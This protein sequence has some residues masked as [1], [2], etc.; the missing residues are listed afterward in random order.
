MNAPTNLGEL[1]DRTAD[2]HA[3]ALVELDETL[4]AVEY[5]FGELDALAE[6]VAASLAARYERGERVALLAANS[7]HYVATVLG[8]MRAG[9]IAVPVNFR[10]PR[11]LIADV[12]A[13]S[14]A[15]LVF[16]DAKR[17]ADVP[18]GFAA[19]AFDA[20]AMELP[21]RLPPNVTLFSSF[22][23]NERGT[24][25]TAIVPHAD[26]PALMLYT[27]GS[28]GRP[29]GVVLSHRSHLWVVRT[30]LQSQPLQGERVLIAA[31]LFHMNALALAFLAL[32]ARATIVMLPQFD[33][34]NY[35]RAVTGWRCT[36][37]TAVPPMIAMMMQEH[38]LLAQSDFSSVRYVRMGS[39]PVSAA[40][41]EQIRALLPNA[42]V[43]NAYGTTEGGPVVFGPHPQDLPTPPLSVGAAHPLVSL[44]LVDEY[45]AE[46]DEGEL[47]LRSPA[48]MNGYHNRPD[49]RAPLTPDG[50]Y[51]TG[52][53]FQRDT[54]GFYTFV[55][56]RDDMFVCGGEN[57]Y[58]GEVE[59][60]LERHPLVAQAC[61]VPVPDAIKGE[62][63]VAFVVLKAAAQTDEK[64]L[65]RFAL[66]QAPAF[67]HPRRV[68]FVGALPVASTNKFDRASL[69]ADAV[70][71]I[72]M[73]SA[74]YLD[75]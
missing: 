3:L 6:S 15:R 37:L 75:Q 48:L 70:R 39:A 74:T 40:L 22:I 54:D 7:A 62:K 11:A 12:I 66:E 47:E 10:F 44:R 73:P 8:I 57:I 68:W 16:C 20:R 32:A 29:K 1:I 19:V 56:R 45:G 42:R 55:G 31:P 72:A 67:Q 28:T 33:A 49:L 60:M 36:W 18:T 59:R 23:A 25:V 34:A 30:R 61:V 64:A 43:I 27:S 4:T 51:R 2:P 46:A 9:L 53:V 71:R 26:E 38:A 50:Y 58:P 69:K 63:P 17:M 52:D 35:I 65:K 21:E 13:D 24:R 14:G 41:Q 5:T